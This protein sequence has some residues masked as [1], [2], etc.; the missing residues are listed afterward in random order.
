ML[1]LTTG[2]TS[3][4]DGSYPKKNFVE[5]YQGLLIK[6]FRYKIVKGKTYR[7]NCL[8]KTNANVKEMCGK[9]KKVFL[10]LRLNL[11]HAQGLFVY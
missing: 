8:L 9:V 1:R 2:L 3:K 6:I 5:T 7:P 11:F 4:A 10:Y